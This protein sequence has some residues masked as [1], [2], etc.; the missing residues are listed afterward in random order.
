MKK[1]LEIGKLS[2]CFNETNIEQLLSMQGPNTE[3]NYNQ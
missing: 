3:T 1:E 2:P